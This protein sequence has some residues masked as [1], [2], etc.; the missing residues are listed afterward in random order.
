[1]KLANALIQFVN[2]SI[3]DNEHTESVSTSEQSRSAF[4]ICVPF[5]REKVGRST[6]KPLNHQN[7]PNNVA[8]HGVVCVTLN[9]LQ[10]YYSAMK[11][12]I[13]RCEGDSV[14]VKCLLLLKIDI[15]SKQYH[16]CIENKSNDC[17]VISDRVLISD[18]EVC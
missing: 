16:L 1:M 10:P 9:I 3:E 8:I 5:A 17:L 6:F 14:F 2:R 11:G 13:R 7:H 12:K 18:V 15:V 4:Q